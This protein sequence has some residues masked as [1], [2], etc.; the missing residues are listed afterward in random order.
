MRHQMSGHLK[1]C[2]TDNQDAERQNI[3]E[4]AESDNISEDARTRVSGAGLV[5]P[6]P[7]PLK[8]TPCPEKGRLGCWNAGS[9]SGRGGS[10][11]AQ[12]E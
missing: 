7:T 8:Q 5:N 12:M 6:T 10:C 9:R 11:A 3:S 2:V 4:D 1:W